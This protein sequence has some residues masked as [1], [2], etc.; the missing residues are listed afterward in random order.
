[1]DE[2][3]TVMLLIVAAIADAY[4]SHRLFKLGGTELNL[5]VKAMFGKRP[6]FSAMLA[7]KAAALA[8]LIACGTEGWHLFGT[9]LWG[10]AAAWNWRVARKLN[11]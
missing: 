6:S 10:G 2:T 3:I 5:L 7:I 4:T 9:A 1:M 11:K 8:A